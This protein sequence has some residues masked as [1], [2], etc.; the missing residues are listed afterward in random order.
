[1]IFAIEPEREP[2]AD[3]VPS[4]N[5]CA[6]SLPLLPS[7]IIQLVNRGNPALFGISW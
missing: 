4:V 3:C 7:S 1:M 6:I 5:T 2:E